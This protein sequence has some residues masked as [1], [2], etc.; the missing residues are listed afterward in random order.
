MNSMNYD[1]KK[2]MKKMNVINHAIMK[3]DANWMVP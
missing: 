2:V 3:Y 1:R